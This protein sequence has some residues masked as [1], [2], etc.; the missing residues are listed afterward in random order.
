MWERKI[1]LRRRKVSDIMSEKKNRSLGFLIF[2]SHI[3]LFHSLF[4]PFM[5][6]YE[7]IRP[8]SE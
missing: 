3:F 6:T 5:E 1:R 2:L 8:H 4:M 7:L